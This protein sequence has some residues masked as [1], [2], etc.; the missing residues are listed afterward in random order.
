MIAYETPLNTLSIFTS[1]TATASTSRQNPRHSLDFHNRHRRPCI[2]IWSSPKMSRQ[3][4]HRPL[5]N[6]PE[7]RQFLQ[8]QFKSL[9]HY[10]VHRSF[11]S[12]FK[13]NSSRFHIIES[14][15]VSPVPSNPIQ[16][17]STLSSPP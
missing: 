14:I 17:A 12:S 16:V 1:T 6:P 13:S 3:P 2:G 7:F 5:M 4:R 9:P 15:G 10:R 11:A 8:I